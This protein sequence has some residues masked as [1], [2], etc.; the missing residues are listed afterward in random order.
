MTRADA[1]KGAGVTLGGVLAILAIDWWAV[2]EYGENEYVQT[3]VLAALLSMFWAG[4]LLT[5][6]REW[7]ATVRAVFVGGMVAFL[8]VMSL[9]SVWL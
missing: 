2:R 5:S 8:T 9:I 6:L 4:L 3:L 1:L 7:P